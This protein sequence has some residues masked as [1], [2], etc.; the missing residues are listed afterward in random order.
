MYIHNTEERPW[1]CSGIAKGGKMDFKLRTDKKIF[2]AHTFP[3]VHGIF[4]LLRVNTI[5]LKYKNK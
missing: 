3:E 4:L 5:S 2:T 1:Q